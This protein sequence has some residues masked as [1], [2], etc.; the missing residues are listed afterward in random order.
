MHVHRI[1]PDLGADRIDVVTRR[2]A[3]LTAVAGLVVL[4]PADVQA[5]LQGSCIVEAEAG[6]EHGQRIATILDE[7]VR[8]EEGAA[9]RQHRLAPLQLVEGFQG[10]VVGDAEVRIEHVG[11]QEGLLELGAGAHQGGDVEGVD[12]VDPA[13][14][15]QAL[16]PVDHLPAAAQVQRALAQGEVAIDV[17]VQQGDA[18]ELGQ[19]VEVAVVQLALVPVAVGGVTVVDFLVLQGVVVPGLAAQEGA[20]V[21]VTQLHL[22]EQDD[23]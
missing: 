18:L 8:R 13:L 10:Q 5:A 19:F 16:A 1:C 20:V 22:A 4:A 9:T 17:G 12:L 21:P 6:V 3:E 11:R 15:E 23:R 2:H 7:V 14:E